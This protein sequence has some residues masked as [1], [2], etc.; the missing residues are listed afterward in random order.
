MTDFKDLLL[1]GIAAA[2]AAVNNK[3]EI[4]DLIESINVKVKEISEGKALFG[5]GDFYKA[6]VVESKINKAVTISS[7]FSGFDTIKY[8]GVGVF[9]SNGKKGIALAEFIMS[10]NGYPCTLMFDGERLVCSNKIE[11]ENALSSLAQYVKTGEAILK[12]MAD[13]DNESCLI[14]KHDSDD[15]IDA[16]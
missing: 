16:K 3:K 13:H 1:V 12:Q 6:K 5:K 9:D 8:E 15:E 2:K 7:F 14:L 10:E 11:L 4:D